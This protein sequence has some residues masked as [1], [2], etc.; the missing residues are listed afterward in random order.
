MAQRKKVLVV[1]DEPNIRD[2]VRGILEDGYDIAEACDGL[3]ALA[4]VRAAK[5][6]L[7]VLDLMM[8]NMSGLDFC[9][10]LKKERLHDMPI[11]MLTALGDVADMEKGYRAGAISY[12]AKPF[13]ATD[14]QAVVQLMLD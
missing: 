4:A 3:Q 7:I 11:V 1:D 14:L 13:N 2:L 8:P 6:D 5:P 12:L 10:T 9:A